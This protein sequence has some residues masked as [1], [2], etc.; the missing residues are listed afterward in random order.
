MA[1]FELENGDLVPGV[2]PAAI[3]MADTASKNILNDLKKN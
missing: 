2:A 1:H 3:Q